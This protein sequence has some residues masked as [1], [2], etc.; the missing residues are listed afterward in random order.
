MEL[1]V[2]DYGSHLFKIMAGKDRSL[3]HWESIRAKAEPLVRELIRLNSE[4]SNG[5]YTIVGYAD[6]KGK[7]KLS[8]V[9]RII[10]AQK[11]LWTVKV[12][13][14]K[15]GD[16]VWVNDGDHEMYIGEQSPAPVHDVTKKGVYIEM[17]GCNYEYI[18]TLSKDAEVLRAPKDWDDKEAVYSSGE[19]WLEQ[20][21]KLGI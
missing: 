19:Y 12:G 18:I 6:E 5:G 8:K 11:R 17:Q 7:S 10:E 2:G 9:E 16:R 15:E 13:K 20:A 21:D 1:T 4:M 3:E 14:L